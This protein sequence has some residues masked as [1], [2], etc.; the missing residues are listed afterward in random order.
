M[1]GSAM[2]CGDNVGTISGSLAADVKTVCT[3]LPDP[4]LASICHNH[5]DRL[6]SFSHAIVMYSPCVGNVSQIYQTHISAIKMAETIC[7]NP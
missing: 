4:G 1:C 2:C 3:S 5:T 7:P 6:H